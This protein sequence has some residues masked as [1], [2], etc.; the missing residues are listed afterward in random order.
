ML[1]RSVSTQQLKI[2]WSKFENHTFFNSAVANV[3]E[4]FDKIVNF[5][6]FEK[7][8]KSIEAYEDDLTGFGRYVLEKF[9]Q[10]VGYLNFSGTQVGE[11]LSNGTQISVVDKSGASIAQ[12]SDKTTGQ[13]VLDPGFS[14]FSVDFFIKVPEQINDNQVVIQKF[15]SLANNFTLAL[16]S[17]SS[18]TSCEVHFAITSGSNYA[19]VSGSLE[20]GT[21]SHIY[22]MYDLIGDQRA[23]LLINDNIHSSDRKSVV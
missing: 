3:K 9:P 23:K 17:S 22:A 15:G 20:K 8:L 6:P 4:S 11:S 10:N 12:I 19:I 21:F 18:T 13:P 7:S 5:Y 1:F 2:D 16:S 14:P